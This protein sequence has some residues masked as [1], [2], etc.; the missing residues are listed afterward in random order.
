MAE[1]SSH[2]EDGQKLITVLSLRT[3]LLASLTHIYILLPFPMGSL[4]FEKL[5]RLSVQ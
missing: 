4:C 1:I 5:E 3:F 2:L